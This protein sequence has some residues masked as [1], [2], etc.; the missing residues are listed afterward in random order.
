MQEWKWSDRWIF[1]L[2]KTSKAQVN[3]ENR[4]FRFLSR[5]RLVKMGQKLSKGV[6]TEV[7]WGGVGVGKSH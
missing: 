5:S 7:D 3:Q 2:E 4:P 1:E 6:M